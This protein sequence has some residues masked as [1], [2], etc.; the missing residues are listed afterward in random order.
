MLKVSWQSGVTLHD[1]VTSKWHLCG[2]WEL[3]EPWGLISTKQTASVRSEITSN[4]NEPSRLEASYAHNLLK[5]VSTESTWQI[6]GIMCGS[7]SYLSFTHPL[8]TKTV[9]LRLC[10]LLWLTYYSGFMMS[11]H[12]PDEARHV[13]GPTRSSV[14]RVAM[15]WTRLTFRSSPQNNA[16]FPNYL[17]TQPIVHLADEWCTSLLN[18]ILWASVSEGVC[19]AQSNWSNPWASGSLRFPLTTVRLYHRYAIQWSYG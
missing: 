16:R 9:Q 7:L 12:T 18:G 6:I 15:F 10:L 11:Q 14:S 2:C 4:P 8:H 3:D 17:M 19:L 5:Q 1:F 13:Y